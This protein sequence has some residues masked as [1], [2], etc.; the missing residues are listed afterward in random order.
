MWISKGRGGA[1]TATERTIIANLAMEIVCD[2]YSVPI[3]QMTSP[4]RCRAQ[5]ALARQ[6]AMYLSHVIGQ[7]SLSDIS[8]EFNRDRTTASYA[9]HSIEDRRDS[10]IFNAQIEHMEEMLHKNIT[11]TLPIGVQRR[12]NFQRFVRRKAVKRSRSL[13][14]LREWP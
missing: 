1:F 11:T 9:C 2:A 5:V 13:R 8:L 10:P 6:T 14:R 12:I 4:S 3:N 7:L